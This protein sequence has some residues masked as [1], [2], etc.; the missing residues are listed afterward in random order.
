MQEQEALT[1][2][3]RRIVM[4]GEGVHLAGVFGLHRWEGGEDAARCLSCGV[5]VWVRHALR[6]TPGPRIW[7]E[8]YAPDGRDW[9]SFPEGDGWVTYPDPEAGAPSCPPQDVEARCPW[10]EGAR[11]Y[12]RAWGE[13]QLETAMRTW[14]GRHEMAVADCPEPG[15][16]C[17]G[18]DGGC[19][20]GPQRCT[21]RENTCRCMCPVCLG[22]TPQDYGFDGDY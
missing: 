7:L 20:W 17:L 18:A 21:G 15:P 8:W 13:V 6:G 9:S 16:V 10:Q 3:V 1:G 22:E 12:G 14:C 19:M 5:S 2:P 4:H 11:R